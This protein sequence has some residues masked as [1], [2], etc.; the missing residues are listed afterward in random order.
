MPFSSPFVVVGR[1]VYALSGDRAVGGETL[2][3][4]SQPTNGLHATKDLA[5]A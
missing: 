3:N 4:A 5:A 2:L 1:G